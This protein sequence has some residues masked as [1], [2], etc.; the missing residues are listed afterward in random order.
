M[1]FVQDCLD[2]FILGACMDLLGIDNLDARPSRTKLPEFI[3]LRPQQEQYE[4]IH[5]LSQQL[6][7]VYVKVRNGNFLFHLFVTAGTVVHIHYSL[8][9]LQC[10]PRVIE[11]CLYNFIGHIAML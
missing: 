6:L 2:A 5:D 1:T 7:D 3:N 10:I 11:M 8:S 9:V 4:W